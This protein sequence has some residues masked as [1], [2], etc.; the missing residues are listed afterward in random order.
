MLGSLAQAQE[1]SECEVS[2]KGILH[3]PVDVCLPR[4]LLH[5]QSGKRSGSQ[6]I[7]LLELGKHIGL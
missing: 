1:S 5:R 4:G 6:Q 7:L 2:L 3:Q